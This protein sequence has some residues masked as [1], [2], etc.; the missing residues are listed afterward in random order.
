MRSG[1]FV[2]LLGGLLAFLPWP[3]G[4]AAEELDPAALRRA[5][6][7]YEA[8]LRRLEAAAAVRDPLCVA[9]VRAD[10]SLCRRVEPGA[11]IPCRLLAGLRGWAR[12]VIPVPSWTSRHGDSLERRCPSRLPPGH[13]LDDAQCLRPLVS[14]VLLPGGAESPGSPGGGRAGG[15]RRDL[16]V[17]LVNPFDRAARCR[18]VASLEYR[19]GPENRVE[20]LRLQA[21]S[22]LDRRLPIRYDSDTRVAVAVACTWDP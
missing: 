14:H 21:R 2:L 5:R 22:L 13:V 20:E 19:D 9:L 11:R 15:E 10:P 8:C 6:G 3:S 7:P 1:H 4:S 12:R 17:K 18:I 16:L